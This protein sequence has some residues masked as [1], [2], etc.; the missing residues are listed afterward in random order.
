MIRASGLDADMVAK[1]VEIPTSWNESRYTLEIGARTGSFPGM[2]KQRTFR[3]VLVAS[4]HGIGNDL[5][6][7]ADRTVRYT[8]RKTTVRLLPNR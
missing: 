3:V 8:G 7:T 5:T 6:A 2:L 1:N 4:R